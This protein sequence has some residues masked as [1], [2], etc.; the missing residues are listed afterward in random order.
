[1]NQAPTGWAL[2]IHHLEKRNPEGGL[3]VSLN[4]G[5]HFPE[6]CLTHCLP[7][8]SPAAGSCEEEL[9]HIGK[10]RSV[11]VTVAR[12]PSPLLLGGEVPFEGN[13]RCLFV[14]E[15]DRQAFV[16]RFQCGTG[17]PTLDIALACPLSEGVL[18]IG[19]ND[20]TSWC[21]S[22]ASSTFA[23]SS[24]KRSIRRGNRNSSSP[25]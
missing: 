14:F 11:V 15:M 12:S 1:M 10:L 3:D 20:T 7:K 2:H 9:S 8:E 6:Y 18:G 19:R 24:G 4:L 25:S 5:N 16:K 17:V 23:R 22:T 13:N 21:C